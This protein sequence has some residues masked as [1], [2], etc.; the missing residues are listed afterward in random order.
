MGADSFPDEVEALLA[1][2]DECGLTLDQAQSRIRR[3]TDG[4]ADWKAVARANRIALRE[5]KMM[6]ESIG[7]RL[8]AVRLI[9]LPNARALG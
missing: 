5:I 9:G 3:I 4:L 8:E 2:A 7:P 6:T 1:L